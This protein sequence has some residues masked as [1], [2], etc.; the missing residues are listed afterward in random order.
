ME[1]KSK[2][3][4]PQTLRLLQTTIYICIL[5]VGLLILVNL[6]NSN[7]ELLIYWA[8]IALFTQTPLTIGLYYLLRKNIAIK[9][10]LYR[11]SKYI[12]VS[13]GVFGVTYVLM[14]QFLNYTENLIH[15]IPNIL[16]FLVFGISL[17]AVITYLTDSKIRKLVTSIIKELKTRSS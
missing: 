2:L 5:T 8:C 3:F 15:F 16:F 7:Q 9:M 4:F 11:I 10:E 17:Y 1:L 6:Q 14:N 13:V 12:L